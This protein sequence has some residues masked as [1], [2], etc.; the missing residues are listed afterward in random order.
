MSITY[1]KILRGIE[2][3]C[4][5]ARDEIKDDAELKEDFTDDINLAFSEVLV[6]IFS[7]GGVWQY[8]D[9]NHPKFPIIKTNLASGQRSYVFTKDEDDN[10]ILDIYKIVITTEDGH[11]KEIPVVNQQAYSSNGYNLENFNDDNATGTPTKADLTANGIFFDI[12][13]NYDKAGGLEVYINRENTF[14]T[15]SD[16]TKTAGFNPLFH[17]YLILSPSYKYARN[18]SL[19]NVSL[20][21]RDKV[22]MEEKLQDSYGKRNR[23]VNRKLQANV[24]NNK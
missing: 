14:F 24:E 5:F 3:N 20:L 16:T 6:T 2:K 22:I 12:I 17:E 18:H 1:E 11:K 10:F 19:P 13:P 7:G 15:T 8:D 9:I 21:E 4:G 23:A